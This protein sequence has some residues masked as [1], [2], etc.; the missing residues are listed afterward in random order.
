M[1]LRSANSA[2]MLLVLLFITAQLSEADPFTDNAALKTAA[3][4]YCSDQVTAEST[5]GPIADWD[6]SA[7]TSMTYLF[8]AHTDSQCET[9]CA[10]FNGDI[11]SWNTG[12]V[13][14]MQVSGLHPPWHPHRSPTARLSTPLQYCCPPSM[15][16]VR[17]HVVSTAVHTRTAANVR[18]RIRFDGL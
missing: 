10:N 17:V 8:C 9:A 15:L 11:S 1:T 16:R 2:S 7:I 3:H 5:Y 18:K 4:A 6:V 12:S 13:T 14:Q